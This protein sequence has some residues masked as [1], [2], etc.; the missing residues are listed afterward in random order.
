MSPVDFIIIAVLL[1]FAA[2]AVNS[3]RKNNHS[4]KGQC[5]YCSQQ[6]NK[7]K[8]TENQ[9]TADSLK[10]YFTEERK[11]ISLENRLEQKKTV[12]FHQTNKGL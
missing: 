5:K 1:L 8:T 7:S 9:D 10:K 6:K 2:L 3:I 4:C 11:K 12:K